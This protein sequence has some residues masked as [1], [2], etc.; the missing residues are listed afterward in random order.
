MEEGHCTHCG[1]ISE[2]TNWCCPEQGGEAS[3]VLV[4]RGKSRKEEVFTTA[5]L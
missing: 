5:L 3:Q 1:I 2:C 4:V